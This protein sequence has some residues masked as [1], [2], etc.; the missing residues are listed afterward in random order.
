MHRLHH[1]ILISSCE[2][3]NS[4]IMNSQQMRKLKAERLSNLLTVSWLDGNGRQNSNLD[5]V[6]PDWFSH[7]LCY[8]FSFR[9][10]EPFLCL[11]VLN[12]QDNTKT[13]IDTL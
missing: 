13:A 6:A 4:I 10:Q 3:E 7:K 1:L 2:V 9:D 11:S 8:I 12:V 5:K